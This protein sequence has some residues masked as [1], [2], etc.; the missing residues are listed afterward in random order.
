MAPTSSAAATPWRSPST[1]SELRR[2]WSPSREMATPRDPLDGAIR[3]IA[4]APTFLPLY[5]MYHRSSLSPTKQRTI[6]DP[7]PASSQDPGGP[8]EKISP[9]AA[10]LLSAGSAEVLSEDGQAL[11]LLAL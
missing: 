4:G 1:A 5:H 2:H 3:S 11:Q 7:T 6:G 8:L 10:S 9:S